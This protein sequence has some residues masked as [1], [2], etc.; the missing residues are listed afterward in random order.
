MNPHR[1]EVYK[2]LADTVKKKL[3]E[4][5]PPFL[6]SKKLILD[7]LRRIVNEVIDSILEKIASQ[8]DVGDSDSDDNDSHDCLTFS[9]R[10]S[11]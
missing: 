4:N 10:V 2:K 5:M 7:D 1:A 3:D 8:E 6:S 11:H 9:S